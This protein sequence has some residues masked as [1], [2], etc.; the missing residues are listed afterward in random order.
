MAEGMIAML[1]RKSTL[2]SEATAIILA[3]TVILHRKWLL[4]KF[5]GSKG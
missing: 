5:Q 4:S 3:E 1:R 2:Q